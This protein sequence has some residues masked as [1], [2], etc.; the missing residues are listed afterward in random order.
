MKALK[1][2]LAC[3]VVLALCLPAVSF[4]RGGMGGGKG[5]GS[6]GWGMNSKYGRMYNP[7]TVETVSGEV[8]KV[9][10]VT[11]IKGMSYG[12][13]LVL[14]T[15]KGDISV[16]LGPAWYIDRQDATIKEG[17]KVDVKGS[18]VEIAG[19]PVVIAAEVKKGDETLMLRDE[20]GVPLWSGW[21]RR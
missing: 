20:S 14:K 11:P 10:K 13:H 1:L 9:D 19:K 18:K 12:I 15:D 6:C 17:D 16:H 3:A 4:A 7:Q 5:G 21:R 2:V 8:V